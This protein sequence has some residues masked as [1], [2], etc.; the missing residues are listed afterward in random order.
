VRGVPSPPG[1]DGPPR[2]E[3]FHDVL[4]PAIL[5]W[6]ARH[7]ADRLERQKRE[8][9]ERERAAQRR[10][11]IFRGL[12]VVAGGLLVIALAAI[13][14]TVIATSHARR[15]RRTA[16][17][18]QLV[19]SALRN[20]D[21][22]PELSALLSLRALDERQTS[23]AADSLR[24]AVPRLEVNRAIPTGS[25]VYHVEF[26][27]DGKRVLA[28]SG[29]W[30]ARL[31]DARSGKQLKAFKKRGAD[32]YN[33]TLS[34][35]GSAV[36]SVD[37]NDSISVWDADTAERARTLRAGYVNDA[38]FRGDG[39]AIA[40]A[41]SFGVAKIWSVK[42]ARS[43]RAVDA[44]K[45]HPT[46]GLRIKAIRRPGLAG[47]LASVAFSP[48]GRSIL[49]A[50]ADGAAKMW[51]VRSGKRK[52]TFKRSNNGLTSASF[53]S[54]GKR[55]VTGGMDATARVWDVRS[56]RQ[57]R[58]LRTSG[59]VQDVGLSR[60]GTKVVTATNLGSAPVWNVGNGDQI[61]NLASHSG[62]V[63]SAE[64]NE[65]ATKVVTGA[66]DGTV[67]IW[68]ASPRDL[69]R[70]LQ[71]RGALFDADFD[72]SGSV[73][74]AGEASRPTKWNWRTGDPQGLAMAGVTGAW[75]VSTSAEGD[76]A[77]VRE[78]GS[79]GIVFRN[80][81]RRSFDADQSITSLEFSHDGRTVAVADG[82]GRVGI[83]SPLRSAEPRFTYTTGKLGAVT[84]VFNPGDSQ[85][86][87]AD[88]D[89]TI[90]IWSTKTGNPVGG[91]YSLP[92]GTNPRDAVFSPDGRT[93]A[94]ADS[95]GTATIFDL[96]TRTKVKRFK[97]ASASLQTIRFDPKGRWLLTSA[98]D[99]S[100]RI[101]DVADQTELLVL[102]AGVGAV[103]GAV[104]SPDAKFVL[105]AYDDGAA[106]IWST[107]AAA[108]L[109]T[110]KRIAEQR[111]S[112]DLTADE[113]KT[114]LAGID[115]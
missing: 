3:I 92:S 95:D 55:V 12:L 115:G 53:S 36:L 77:F 42:K 18:R 33:A 62:V 104:F 108:P 80:G 86:L 37:S 34:R 96:G 47:S 27:R 89:G 68:D 110:V 88:V 19:A 58:V 67:R 52:G 1:E 87:T 24:Q 6:R 75:S 61:T 46:R 44:W 63:Y 99:G 16:E 90:R 20:L 35:D 28:V 48:D 69:V 26:S 76:R 85:L 60:N 66:L 39:T 10:A 81:G 71:S 82:Y 30:T 25:T 111:L 65:H 5:D 17:S 107:E 113:K 4:A 78:D 31:F 93:I 112:R 57:L 83:Y 114:Y 100:V 49:T 7:T 73:V 45:A 56:A 64:F 23:E 79:A 41:D 40:T 84:A 70:L 98:E 91:K 106:R 102:Q 103:N 74:T 94:V 101:W 38:A 59:G 9:E 29:D 109:D 72:P 97:V 22:D 2:F 8:A 51:D 14:L 13:V 105:A 15:D 43:G 11:Q 21:S 32:I 50:G 54:N